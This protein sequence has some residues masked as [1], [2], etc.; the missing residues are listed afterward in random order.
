[1]VSEVLNEFQN[2]ID[3][4]LLIPSSG[5]VFELHAGD[6][7]VYSKKTTGKHV[8]FAEIAPN[9]RKILGRPNPDSDSE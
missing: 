8:E 9:L 7:V 1:M 6:T 5:G 3:D 2:H 4:F